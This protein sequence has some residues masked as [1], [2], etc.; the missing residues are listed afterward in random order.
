MISSPGTISGTCCAVPSALSPHKVC[1]SSVSEPGDKYI[2][3]LL[4]L[5]VRKSGFVGVEDA[6]SDPESGSFTGFTLFVSSTVAF[7]TI[8]PL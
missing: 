8:P 5:A 7:N 4:G 3:A 1:N 2:A 6:V